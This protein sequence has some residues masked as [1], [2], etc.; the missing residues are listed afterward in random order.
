MATTLE[1]DVKLIVDKA[2]RKTADKVAL[3]MKATIMR[4][5]KHPTGKL[6]WS[7]KVTHPSAYRY[8]V[9]PTATNNGFPYASAF[10][11]GRKAVRPKKKEFLVFSPERDGNVIRTKYAKK[12][13]GSRFI[14]K[15]YNRVT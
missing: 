12:F 3:E 6:A 9:M 14:R 8:V 2:M 11:T 13:S 1:D 15:T 5:A 10:D 7:V 4:V